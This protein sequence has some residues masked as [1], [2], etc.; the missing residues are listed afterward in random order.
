MS[1]N[2]VHSE[3][4][5]TLPTQLLLSHLRVHAS[6]DDRHRTWARSDLRSTMKV[7]AKVGSGQ[8]WT[9]IEM[10]I[11]EHFTG[12]DIYLK[13]TLDTVSN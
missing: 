6:P 8:P 12:F 10:K 2:Y 7:D 3:Q 5:P 9:E 13:F 11:C 1:W 4:F